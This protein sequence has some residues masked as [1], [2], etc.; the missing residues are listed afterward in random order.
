[1]ISIC[2]VSLLFSSAHPSSWHAA[3]EEY[4]PQFIERDSA[5]YTKGEGGERTPLVVTTLCGSPDKN[6]ILEVNGG[7]LVLADFDLDGDSD[8]VL[9][10]GS[11]IERAE[12]NEAGNAPRLFLN[13]GDGSF[14]QAGGAWEMSGGRWGMGGASG[15]VDGDG[16]SDLVITEWGVDR[17]LM[18]QKG[19]GFSEI[20][21]AGLKGK[22]WGTSAAFLDYDLDGSLDLV[23]V[24]YLAF[25]LDEIK[26]RT[27]D[28]CHWKGQSVMCGPEG[29]SPVHD[30]LYRGDGMGEF[31]EVTRES[32]FRPSN[33]GFGLGVMTLDFDMDG[34]TDIYVTNDSTPNHLWVNDGAGQLDEQGLRLGAAL[35][36]GGKEQAGMGVAC[37]DIDGDGFFDLFVTNF[38]G[39]SNELYGS[40]ARSGSV[41]FRA[42]TNKV[43]MGGASLTYLGW[44]TSMAD[45][46]HDG[47]IDLFALNGHVYPQSNAQGTDTQYAQPDHFYRNVGSASSA[48]MVQESLSPSAPFVSR[49]SSVADLDGDGDLDLVQIEIDAAV[50]VFENRG[51]PGHWL[52]L[53]L[54]DVGKNR[55]ALGAVVTAVAGERR[56]VGE[57]RTAGGFQNSVPAE[58][59]FGL[60]EIEALDRLEIRWPDGEV[61][62]VSNPK[63]DRVLTIN[64]TVD[65][66][67][68]T[69]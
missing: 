53:R 33:A 48:R 41:R 63:L 15:D 4:E 6:Y 37:A 9:I 61:T 10:D 65:A 68:E 36:S 34:D 55:E 51:G 22:R 64:R 56:F 66:K 11:T 8:L 19:N 42:R 49:A 62:L 1:M 21:D 27:D 3:E 28:V 54:R 29:L 44:G 35:D 18:N 24:N 39:E 45:F 57:V 2:F 5:F 40:S 12:A 43:G 69:R 38:S 31:K 13:A 30:Q 16:F 59:H 20:T 32:G 60:G 52:R 7:G 14:D 23:I 25:Y 46:D 67:E 50:R 26:S 17:L 58:I 47:D